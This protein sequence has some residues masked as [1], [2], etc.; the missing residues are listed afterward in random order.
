MDV[1][2]RDILLTTLG[3]SAVKS[4]H[5]QQEDSLVGYGL[6]MVLSKNA[7]QAL[8]VCKK[9]L[10]TPHVPP[11]VLCGPEDDWELMT[12]SIGI[13]VH[14]YVPLPLDPADVARKVVRILRRR[15]KPGV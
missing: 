15:G 6:V 10:K 1:A 13:G 8:D 7:R 4:V 3:A 12:T 11:I 14:D 9:F 2:S 5:I